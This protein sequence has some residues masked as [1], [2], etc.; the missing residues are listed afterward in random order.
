M[1]SLK[2]QQ[3][4]DTLER[5]F[6]YEFESIRRDIEDLTDA[7]FRELADL[8]LQRMKSLTAERAKA[9]GA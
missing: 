6:A 5:A 4:A 8:M 9:R 1:Q 7:E 3:I 2:V